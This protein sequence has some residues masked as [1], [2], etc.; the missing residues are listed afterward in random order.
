[1]AEKSVMRSFKKWAASGIVI[2]C[3]LLLGASGYGFYMYMSLK[4]T[5]EK[6]YEPLVR[7]ES[8]ERIDPI[9]ENPVQVT[10]TSDRAA[11]PSVHA[12]T[13]LLLGIDQRNEEQGRSDTIMVLTYNPEREKLLMVNIPRDTRSLI[14]GKGI[15]DKMNHAYAF[16]GTAMS[17]ATVENFLGITIDYYIK[18]NMKGFQQIIDAFDGVQVNNKASFTYEGVRF[19][20]GNLELDGKEAL[21]Y[22][23]MRMEDPRGDL[24]RNERQQQVIGSLLNKGKSI[25]TLAVLNEILEIVGEQVRTNFT[26]DEMKQMVWDYKDRINSVEA[27]EIAGEGSMIDGIYYYIVEDEERRRIHELIMNQLKG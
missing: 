9:F 21:L 1:M 8:T 12:F 24:G 7:L 18:V 2:L 10:D 22:S 13:V 15:E 11:A 25:K 20:E 14:V 19:P 26:F 5:A 6:M 4:D 17:V 27:D 3:I 23:R 16:G